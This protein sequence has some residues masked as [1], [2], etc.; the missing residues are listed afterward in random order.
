MK[1]GDLISWK[2]GGSFA[3]IGGECQFALVTEIVHARVYYLLYTGRQA[4]TYKENVRVV[5]EA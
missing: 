4:W 2:S 3:H 5:N 1:P